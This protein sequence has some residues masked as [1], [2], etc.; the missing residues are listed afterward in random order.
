MK[1]LA[2]LLCMLTCVLGLSAC[3]S[4][5]PLTE[6][7]QQYCDMAETM[8]TEF[9]VP[10]MLSFFDDALANDYQEN[11]NVHELKAIVEDRFSYALYY[12]QSAYGTSYD[13]NKIEVDG[14]AIRNG[15]VSFNS[16]KEALGTVD[17][18]MGLSATSKVSGD[19]IIV[20]VPLTGSVMDENGKA[21]TAE[22]EIIYSNDIFLKVQSCTLNMNQ[23]IGDLMKKASSD[24]LM[25]MGTVFVV[26]ILISLIIYAL[27]FI[28][29]LQEKMN[30]KS[31]KEDLQTIKSEAVNHTIAQI[32][33]KEERK[34]YADDLELVAV[35]AAAVAASMGAQSTDGFVVRS[36]RKRR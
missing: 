35:I 8:S 25:G 28:P 23:T 2:A 31:K 26:L 36:I 18:S 3:G 17:T 5:K 30:N 32:I 1:K 12:V 4:E 16:S 29:K 19:E 7:N 22:V 15:I 6:L 33:E 21:I 24:T 11:F 20:T 9:V 13:F 27:G 34:E 10:Y 14:N